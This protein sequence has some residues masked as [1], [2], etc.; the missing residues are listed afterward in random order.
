M[1]LELSAHHMSFPVTD[2]A[3]SRRFYEGV[4]GLRSIPRPD[5]GPIAGIWYGAGACEVHLIEVPT[6]VDVGAPPPKLSPLARHSAF[7]IRDYDAT[8]A[9][10]RQEGLEVVESP[11]SRQMW[12]CD[13]DGHIIELIVPV[14]ARTE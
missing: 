11:R 2:L 7:A 4:L 1:A 3:R 14:G 10:L 8:L 13:P 9:M 5:L 12:V 6:G